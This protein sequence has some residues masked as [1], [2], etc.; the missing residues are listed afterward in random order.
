MP[1]DR[2][3]EDIVRRLRTEKLDDATFEK[4]AVRIANSYGV[5][6]MP[7]PGGQD[8]GY[9]G[10]IVDLDGRRLPS[11]LVVTLQKDGLANLRKNLKRHS[12]TYPEAAKSAFF[13]TTWPKTNQQRQDLTTEAKRLGYTLLGIADEP[14]VAEHLYY[15]P[16]SCYELLGFRGGPSALSSLP[17]RRRPHWDIELVARGDA[18]DR[19]RHLTRDTMLVGIPG[20]GKTSLLSKVSAENLG[21]FAHTADR[22]LLAPDLREYCP[23]A[24]F[25][26]GLGEQF[27]VVQALVSLREEL[28]INFNIVL[29]GWHEDEG[30]VQLL[31]IG[32][33][34]RVRLDRLELDELVE[35][36]RRVG[37]MGPRELIRNIVHQAGG[38]PGLAVT[39]TMAC[40]E[41][42]VVE[43][44]S[45]AILLRHVRTVLRALP[46]DER[47]A[48]MALAAISVGGDAGMKP[49]EVAKAI[50]MPTLELH[51]LLS[52]IEAGG[53]IRPRAG[54]NV[55]VQPEHLR[56]VLVAAHFCGDYPVKAEPFLD[57]APSRAS[58]LLTIVLATRHEREPVEL[59][60]LLTAHHGPKVLKAYAGSGP[61]QCRWVITAHPE[62]LVVVSGAALHY[63]PEEVLPMLIATAKGDKRELHSTPEHPL[64][65]INDWCQGAQP[66]KG[67]AVLRREMTVNAALRYL[68][69]NDDV[70]TAVRAFAQ[71][72]TVDHEVVYSDPGQGMTSTHE[73]RV[74]A[75]DEIDAVIDLWKRCCSSLRGRRDLPW[76]MLL[77]AAR[78]AS[79]QPA[80][81]EEGGAESRAGARRLTSTIASDIFELGRDHPGVAHEARRLTSEE[82]GLPAKSEQERLYAL[83]FGDHF[84]PDHNKRKAEVARQLTILAEQWSLGS[85]EGAMDVL[86]SLS[87]AAADVRDG[88]IS[89][90]YL[91][92]HQLAER[93]EV[94]PWLHAAIRRN[95]DHEVIMPF[96]K[97]AISTNVPGWGDV[98]R[99]CIGTPSEAAA[100][101]GALLAGGPPE[102]MADVVP[103]LPRYTELAGLVC[104]RNEVSP[105]ALHALLS[106]TDDR[107][108]SAAA[109][110]LWHGA[111]GNIEE[112]P[113]P[114]WRDAFLRT[115]RAG[116]WMGDIL[117]ANG[118]LAFEWLKRRIEAGDCPTLMEGN[119][120]GKAVKPLT[121][122]QR[123]ELLT[124]LSGSAECYDLVCPLFGDSV[125]VFNR[126]LSAGGRERLC[127][128][129]L[130]RPRDEVWAQFVV[131]GHRHGM[132]IDDLTR[133]SNRELGFWGLES[134]HL[135]E[136][137]EQVGPFL[138]DLREPV[139]RVAQRITELLAT[140]RE[141][142]LGD[143]HEERVWGW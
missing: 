3:Y 87:D 25:V 124:A 35:V 62:Y 15:H 16:N 36:V 99:S 138:K 22:E 130:G 128:M 86:A 126:I 88:G 118:T 1:R 102:L 134:A 131:A 109:V 75:P 132:S 98:A 50:D 53:V 63:I 23:K 93:V 4:I 18:L 97:K 106:H 20:S 74:I 56:S 112:A 12:D 127:R 43:V 125:A 24:V 6:V 82:E 8:V 142:A 70:H 95:L 40:R 7:T 9:D 61:E 49:D 66:G 133:A 139:R 68:D 79:L 77:G 141:R 78:R 94:L 57:I 91:L 14:T 115:N 119:V 85:P 105:V 121:E 13:A 33:D 5:P 135:Q 46:L 114:L 129:A 69:D 55:S 103:L 58:A 26:D 37:L 21:L 42:N 116:S 83:L 32:P 71:A 76:R 72:L 64:R 107:V 117:S 143:E 123:V 39:L 30:M 104:M 29:T 111:K 120:V 34:H 19:L 89:Q 47:R 27:R 28:R 44:V 84:G 96:L 90:V 45:G 31:G 59:R 108:A 92:A 101:Q 122:D 100:V 52:D 54:G 10:A 136:R 51:H 67:E 113:N 38:S 2:L 60:T 80:Q 48:E 73:R 41:G 17:P 110:H 65:I 81:Y 11:P 140:A 137:I